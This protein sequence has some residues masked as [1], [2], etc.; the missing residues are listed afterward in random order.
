MG[1]KKKI[2]K[3]IVSIDERI[4]EHKEKQ[5]QTTRPELA[6]YYEFEIKKLEREKAKKEKRL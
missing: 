3:G 5:K 4:R 6:Q 2:R 1:G